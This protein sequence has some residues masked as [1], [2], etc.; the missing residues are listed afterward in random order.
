MQGQS[1]YTAHSP[2]QP[3]R[4]VYEGGWFELGG[5][6]V[7]EF[8]EAGWDWAGMIAQVA[9]VAQGCRSFERHGLGV[10]DAMDGTNAY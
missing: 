2:A 5:S 6:E 10:P 7:T 9:N 4:N 1:M 8:K 3:H